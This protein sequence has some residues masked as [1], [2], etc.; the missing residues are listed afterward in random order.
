MKLLV[1]PLKVAQRVRQSLWRQFVGI[2][3]SVRPRGSVA[4]IIESNGYTLVELTV[5][6]FLIGI[7]L[8][9]AVPR[10][11]DSVLSG[12]EKSA[13]RRFI[14]KVTE[15]REKALR[16]KQAYQLHLDISSNRMWESLTDS[17]SEEGA[18]D[19]QIGEVFEDARDQG[20]E[21]PLLDVDFPLKDKKSVGEVILRFTKTGYIEPAV[22]HLGTKVED[23]YTVHLSPFLGILNTYDEYVELGTLLADDR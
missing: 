6:V 12:D 9:L 17:A 16:D 13:A 3:V 8:T 10:I 18:E 20:E 22:V 11:R 5:V 14:G 21:I 4:K 19:Q 7:M 2:I 15:V 1:E 23:A